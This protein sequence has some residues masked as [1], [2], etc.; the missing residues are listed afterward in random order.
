MGREW[1]DPVRRQSSVDAGVVFTVAGATKRSG[2]TS[3]TGQARRLLKMRATTIT[4]TNHKSAS[5]PKMRVTELDPVDYPGCILGTPTESGS[6]RS[7]GTLHLS[8]IYRDME[9]QALLARKNEMGED[10]LSWY[11]A[12]GFL[13]EHVFSAAYVE[14]IRQRNLVRPDEW[15]CDGIVGSPDLIRV[16]DWTLIELKFRWMS[17]NKFDQLEK[18]FWLE[19]VQIKGYC[20]MVG[21]WQ[22]ELHVFFCNGDYRPPRPRVRAVSLQFTEQEIEESWLVIKNHAKRR[23]ML[24]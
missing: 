5:L 22:A 16:D 3:D 6:T 17:S 15:E 11:G 18:H 14:S 23:G 1:S 10:E 4:V 12:A 24:R 2:D 20:K 7:Q 8:T 19:L 21:T 13:W 9:E